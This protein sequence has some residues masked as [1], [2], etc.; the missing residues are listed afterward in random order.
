MHLGAQV[1]RYIASSELEVYPSR[2]IH[3]TLQLLTVS[4]TC[5]YMCVPLT[6][7]MV[8]YKRKFPLSSN[9]TPFSNFVRMR[10]CSLVPRPNSTVIDLGT[11]L[12]HKRNRELVDHARA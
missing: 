12:V 5:R 2:A 6:P 3:S 1:Q 7:I 10:T 9:T 11:R 4:K 8:A